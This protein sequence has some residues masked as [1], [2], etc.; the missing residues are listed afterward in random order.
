MTPAERKRKQRARERAARA[1]SAGT[2]GYAVDQAHSPTDFRI[3]RAFVESLAGRVRPCDQE[4]A[5]QI[6]RRVIGDTPEDQARA[7][8]ALLDNEPETLRA[9]VPGSDPNIR[10]AESS[11]APFEPSQGP[12]G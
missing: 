10:Y 8:L 5:R 4:I 2:D 6:E 1:G 3:L 9:I 12:L 11:V 7:M